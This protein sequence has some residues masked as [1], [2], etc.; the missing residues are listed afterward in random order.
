M[1]HDTQQE[2]ARL[3]S[4]LLSEHPDAGT[5]T[6][7]YKAYNADSTDEDPETYSRALLQPTKSNRGLILLAVLL[8]LGIAAV[9]VYWLVRFLGVL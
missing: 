3:E 1:F 5:S 7:S 8:A 2:L 6:R 4:A 9:A